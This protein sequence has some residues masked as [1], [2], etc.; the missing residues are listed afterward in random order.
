MRR[1]IRAALGVALLILM[2]N[3]GCGLLVAEQAYWNQ[4][5]HKT[6]WQDTNSSQTPADR[7]HTQRQVVN[8]D[9]RAL[10]DDIDFILMRERPSRLSRWHNR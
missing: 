8:Q 7:M 5:A 4:R 2:A 3:S 9:A 6:F 1:T 10:V